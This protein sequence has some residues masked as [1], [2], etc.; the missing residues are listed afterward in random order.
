[1][2]NNPNNP[3]NPNMANNPNNPNNPNMANNV[4]VGVFGRN[5]KRFGKGR[6]KFFRVFGAVWCKEK[7]RTFKCQPANGKAQAL[8][9]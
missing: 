3:N 8:G 1:M 9:F 2:A 4:M 5:E 7:S 6:G